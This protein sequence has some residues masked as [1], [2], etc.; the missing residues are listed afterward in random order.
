MDTTALFWVVCA[1]PQG[2][3]PP[4]PQ[5]TGS[6]I[7]FDQWVYDELVGLRT[8]DTPD[9]ATNRTTRGAY[10]VPKRSKGGIG[11]WHFADPMEYDVDRSYSI[12]EVVIVSKDNTAVTDGVVSKY[13]PENDF[14]VPGMYVCVKEPTTEVPDKNAPDNKFVHVP[15]WPLPDD[16]SDTDDGEDGPQNYWIPI[17]FGPLEMQDC[18]EGQPKDF[19]HNAAEL[20]DHSSDD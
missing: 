10:V 14:A 4:R 5:G 1:M 17:S 8:S 18:Q 12:D 13:T 20:V 15:I 11:G 6:R 2:H 16:D 9:A 19:V 7:R 3:I